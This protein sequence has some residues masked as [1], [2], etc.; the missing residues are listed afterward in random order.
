MTQSNSKSSS[1][2]EKRKSDYRNTSMT[3]T[4]VCSRLLLRHSRTGLK[5]MH[6]HL[7]KTRQR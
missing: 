4:A 6:N 3:R 2:S 1:G 7:S 5:K